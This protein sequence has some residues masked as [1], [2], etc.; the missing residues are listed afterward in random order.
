MLGISLSEFVVILCI[1]VIFIKPEDMPAIMKVIK[2]FTKKITT[3]KKEYSKA[4]HQL[5]KELDLEDDCENEDT[6]IIVDAEGKTHIAYDIEDLKE[7]LTTES[8]QNK[9]RMN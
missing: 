4:M 2:S 1:A 3:L 5:Q 7:E 6:R 8:A 9:Y